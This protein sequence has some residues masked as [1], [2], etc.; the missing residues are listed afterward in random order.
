MK[1]KEK[2]NRKI[3]NNLFLIG[4]YEVLRSRLN[5]SLLVHKVG[6][7]VNNYGVLSVVMLNLRRKCLL[8]ICF[9]SLTI[10]IQLCV[11]I[12]NLFI[13]I[14]W[15]CNLCGGGACHEPISL[16]HRTSH[17]IVTHG[18]SYSLTTLLLHLFTINM[19]TTPLFYYLVY[20]FYSIYDLIFKFLLTNTINLQ[21]KRKKTNKIELMKKKKD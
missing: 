8:Y 10:H 12:E 15:L 6:F 9:Y 19:S 17:P 20:Y 3:T 18:S 1:I 4:G 13:F 21:N 7:M 5:N 2:K 11:L 16:S 14:W